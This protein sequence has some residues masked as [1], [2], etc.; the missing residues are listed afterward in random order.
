MCVCEWMNLT[1]VVEHF[2]Q[3]VDWNRAIDMQVPLAFSQ[4]HYLSKLMICEMFL[5]KLHFE[6]VTIFIF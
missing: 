6:S 5:G 2:E 3:S 4:A 1:G